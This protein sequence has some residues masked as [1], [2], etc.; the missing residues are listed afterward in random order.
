MDEVEVQVLQLQVL[1]G[2][3][4]G[5]LHVLLVMP[6]VPQLGCDEHVLSSQGLMHG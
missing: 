6:G 4:E 3:Q 2:L 1:Q 5:R